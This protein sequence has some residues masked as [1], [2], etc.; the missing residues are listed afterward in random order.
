MAGP[1]HACARLETVC[2]NKSNEDTHGLEHTVP[3]THML[4]AVILR[5]GAQTN[6]CQAGPVLHCL[7]MYLNNKVQSQ[8]FLD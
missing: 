1:V 3:Q 8:A 5:G 6:L 7:Q 4:A 2:A